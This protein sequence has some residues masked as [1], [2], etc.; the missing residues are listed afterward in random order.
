M[1]AGMA[2]GVA[3]WLAGQLGG[4]AAAELDVAGGLCQ[5]RRHHR[6]LSGVA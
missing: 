2:A 4:L 6:Q 3:V 1:V 5:S